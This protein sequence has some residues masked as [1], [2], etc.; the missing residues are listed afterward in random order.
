MG[1][2]INF[3]MMP[4][5]VAELDAK[6]KEMGF[7]IICN[8][9]PSNNLFLL[10]SLIDESS[11]QKYLTFPEYLDL[12]EI[13]YSE[14]RNDY[15]L[16][17]NHLPA[18]EFFY[19]KF[20]DEQD[21]LYR[22]RLY[23]DTYGLDNYNKFIENIDKLFQWYKRHFKNTKINTSHTTKRAADWKYINGGKLVSMAILKD[24]ITTYQYA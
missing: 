8:R 11:P 17:P 24:N 9:M 21:K 7:V 5:D 2:Q 13:K 20:T 16:S 14:I 12:F 1:R 22:G 15:Y 19:P 10:N 6:V 4:E 3:F 18:L 23:L